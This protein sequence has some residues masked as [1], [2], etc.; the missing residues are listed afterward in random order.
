MTDRIEFV[1][2]HPNGWGGLQQNKIRQ[3][4]VVAGLVP[5]T[6]AGHSRV[7]FVTEGE[8]SLNFCISN[9][10]TT[11]NIKVHIH[12][13]CLFLLAFPP[14]DNITQDGKSVIIVDAG[15]GTVDISSYLFLS[16][17]PIL[18]EEVTSPECESSIPLGH[19]FWANH[20]TKASFRARRA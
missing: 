20:R 3:A 13:P 7:H 4:A 12:I 11:S 9:G 19:C 14:S 2:A 1:L 8:A 15:G 16:T 5:D 6:S 10:L 18:V 17:A